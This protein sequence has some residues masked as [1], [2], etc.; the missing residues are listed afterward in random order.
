MRRTLLTSALLACVALVACGEKPQ[1]STARKADAPAYS[2]TVAATFAA[3]GWKPGDAAS[4]EQA[5]KKRSQ[6][7]NEYV[8]GSTP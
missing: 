4:W 5:L 3:P 8:R 2:G 6:G 7:Q 1:T